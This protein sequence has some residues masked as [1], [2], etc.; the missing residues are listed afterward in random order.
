MVI[1]VVNSQNLP[2]IYYLISVSECLLQK[3]AYHLSKDFQ[4]L[5]EQFLGIEFNQ[6]YKFFKTP[7]KINVLERDH[8]G[9]EVDYILQL[10]KA[11][12]PIEVKWSSAPTFK[13]CTA[14]N[15]IY[16]RIQNSHKRLYIMQNPKS[17]SF[18]G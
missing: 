18:S 2:N 15:T 1:R 14:C 10:E 11:L 13:R 9:P 5:F 7:S 4:H 3:M 6:N 12:L 17:I 8:A 16:A